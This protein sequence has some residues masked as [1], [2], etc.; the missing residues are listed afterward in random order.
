MEYIGLEQ[1]FRNN[2]DIMRKNKNKSYDVIMEYINQI[3]LFT[4]ILDDFRGKLA[5][6]I[7]TNNSQENTV[8]NEERD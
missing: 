7:E 6:E 3:H 8:N 5:K 4:E 1:R 2:D